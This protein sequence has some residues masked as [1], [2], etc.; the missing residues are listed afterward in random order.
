MNRLLLLTG[1]AAGAIAGWLAFDPP[2]PR[3]AAASSSLPPV[4]KTL[5]PGEGICTE[6]HVGSVLNDGVGSVVITNVPAP[7]MP[8]QVYPITVTVERT[9]KSRWGFELTVLKDSDNT[10]AGALANT[11]AFTGTQSFNGRSYMSHTTNNI[12]S[13]GTF[14]GQASGVWTFNWTAPVAGAG[15]VTFYAAGN[16]ANGNGN[17]LGDNIYTTNVS[18]MEGTATDVSATTWGKIKML[19]R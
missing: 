9:A 17:Q 5:A 18:S 16:A 3:R 6:C 12:G 2:A 8:G 11:T 10:I 7:Y 19:Y 15:T 4:A 13:D 1:I 14:Q